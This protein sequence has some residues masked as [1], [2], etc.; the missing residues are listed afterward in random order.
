MIHLSNPA[1]KSS[2]AQ[3]AETVSLIAKSDFPEQW[4]DLIDV[5]PYLFLLLFRRYG[6]IFFFAAHNSQSSTTGPTAFSL[7]LNHIATCNK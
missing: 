7:H 3:V 5:S 1:D 2:R 6:G 4:P